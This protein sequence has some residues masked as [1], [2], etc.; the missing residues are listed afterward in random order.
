MRPTGTPRPRDVHRTRQVSWLTGRRSCLAFPT[1]TPVTVSRQQ[2][3]AHSCGGSAG[4]THVGSPASLLAPTPW[5]G[6]EP[7][8]LGMVGD[9]RPNS[10]C[11]MIE[12]WIVRGGKKS[13]CLLAAPQGAARSDRRVDR[14]PNRLA[15]RGVE[16]GKARGLARGRCSGD[17]AIR[18]RSRYGAPVDPKIEREN[19]GR[20]RLCRDRNRLDQRGLR[21][22]AGDMDQ[23]VDGNYP[24]PCAGWVSLIP[25]RD[26]S[27]RS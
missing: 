7:R 3:T 27:H 10:T 20:P 21:Q 2:L 13:A 22:R 15:D 26:G 23:K 6:E 9:R 24:P 4:L 25:Y 18:A 8:T 16:T 1:R 17:D 14:R 12:L 11:C 19:R 5:G